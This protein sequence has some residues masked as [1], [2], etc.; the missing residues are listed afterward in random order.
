MKRVLETKDV[1][2]QS[3]NYL[4][5]Q[6]LGPGEQ[7]VGALTRDVL[8]LKHAL[9]VALPPWAPGGSRCR[10]PRPLPSPTAAPR[11][12]RHTRSRPRGRTGTRPSP[13]RGTRFPLPPPAR[14]SSV[15]PPTGSA[16]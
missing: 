10:C 9:H 14:R 3:P 11:A 12:S 15:S 5:D 2:G 4:L 6:V 8:G 16:T 7:V 1:A 13:P